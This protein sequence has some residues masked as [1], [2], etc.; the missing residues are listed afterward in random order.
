MYMF[1]HQLEL[2]IEKLNNENCYTFFL[3]FH[4]LITPSDDIYDSP[5]DEIAM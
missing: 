1:H 5:S 3:F 2:V 4:N